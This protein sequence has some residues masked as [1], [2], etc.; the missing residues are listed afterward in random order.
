MTTPHAGT[1]IRVAF[2]PQPSLD[3][4]LIHGSAGEP[5]VI[6]VEEFVLGEDH[7]AVRLDSAGWTSTDRRWRGSAAV[8]RG[9][10]VDANLRSRVVAT[11]RPDVEIIFRQLGGGE[12]PDEETLRGYVHDGEP[13]STSAPLRLGS[14]RAAA[15]FREKRVYRILFANDLGADGL[16]I[17]QAGWRMTRP[18]N[19]ADPQ[20]R[21][22]GTAHLHVGDDSFAWDL[23]RIGI[24]AAWCVDLTANLVSRGDAIGPLLR[25][26]TT[27]MRRQGLIP[28][29][30]E[31]FS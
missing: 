24:G 31:R 16:A 8:S 17:L 19:V 5:E 13:L 6:L 9:I 11:S 20:G 26:L 10:R 15:G 2:D 25:E 18:E 4:Y 1:A 29:T 14:G 23:R 7:S 28:V 30:I 3:Y 22:V 21:V 12:L 27:T